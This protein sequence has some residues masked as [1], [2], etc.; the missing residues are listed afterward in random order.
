M[1]TT[2][3]KPC[4]TCRRRRQILIDMLRE[5]PDRITAVMQADGASDEYI[6]R[7]LGPEGTD[8][9]CAIDTLIEE[10]IGEE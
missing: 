7:Q 10:Q 3:R 9:R 1:I 2:N 8:L 6:A 5:I 4:E